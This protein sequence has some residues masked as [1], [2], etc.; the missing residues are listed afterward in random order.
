[1]NWGSYFSDPFTVTNGLRQGEVL[2]LY[3]FVVYLDDFSIQLG[4]SVVGCITVRNTFVNLLVF[5][6][7]CLIL[8][9]WWITS[10]SQLSWIK[11]HPSSLKLRKMSFSQKQFVSWRIFFLCTELGQRNVS[12]WNL[13]MIHVVNSCVTWCILRLFFVE[14]TLFPLR[15]IALHSYSMCAVPIRSG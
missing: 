10:R 6:E 8:I 15:N 7:G 4:T 2:S 9:S 11:D 3:L 13:W 12:Q 5:A 14:Y 1:M